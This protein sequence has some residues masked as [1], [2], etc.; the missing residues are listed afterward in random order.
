MKCESNLQHQLFAF[1][2]LSV[3]TTA[4]WHVVFALLLEP[5]GHRRS[6]ELTNEGGRH[7]VSSWRGSEPPLAG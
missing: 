3:C 7:S 1:V 2:Y 4:Q 5:R 6:C